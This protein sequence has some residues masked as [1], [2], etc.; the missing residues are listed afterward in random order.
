MGTRD[1]SM[2]AAVPAAIDFHQ[3]TGPYAVYNY[4]HKLAIEAAKMLAGA[5]NRFV[6]C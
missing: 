5:W 1:Y 4:T 6:K 2:F 3:K